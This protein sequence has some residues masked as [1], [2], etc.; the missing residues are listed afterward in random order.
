MATLYTWTVQRLETRPQDGPLIDVVVTAFWQCIGIEFGFGS[1]ACGSCSF[2]A[3]G[4][5]FT[6]YADLT[7]QQ[8]LDWCWASGVDKNATE[9]R[10]QTDINN[11]ISP[12][13][14]NLPLPW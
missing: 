5:P 12:P 11:Q 6:A 3:P 1:S 9:A 14:V 7:E 13:I 2:T 10:I 4:D 8:I